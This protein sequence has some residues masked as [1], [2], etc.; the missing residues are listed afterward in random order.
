MEGN[1]ARA[2]VAEEEY[3]RTASRKEQHKQLSEQFENLQ[4]GAAQTYA[5]LEEGMVSQ[6]DVL[7][8]ERSLL[9]SGQ[10]LLLNHRQILTDTVTLYKALG[11]GWPQDI[12]QV[13]K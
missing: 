3:R 6:L 11:G 1:E 5:Q 12:V 13:R 2:R 4:V 8:V 9:Q 10:S 7:D